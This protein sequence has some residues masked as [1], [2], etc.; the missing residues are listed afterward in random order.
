MM[1]LVKLKRLSRSK[2]F[3]AASRKAAIRFVDVLR[4]DNSKN[5]DRTK[6]KNARDVRSDVALHKTQDS[7]YYEERP[8]KKYFCGFPT[9]NDNDIGFFFG[10][11]V[12]VTLHFA[13]Y[14]Y[15]TI[16]TNTHQR[17]M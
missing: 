2:C 8:G 4:T 5:D 15:Q 10:V 16:N 11:S 6:E 14:S 13:R 1:L 7:H 17:G 3:C 12:A 9:L